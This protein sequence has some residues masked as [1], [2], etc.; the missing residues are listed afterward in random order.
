M[1]PGLVLSWPDENGRRVL[2]HRWAGHVI[3]YVRSV[4][5]GSARRYFADDRDGI[6]VE[7]THRT[8]DAA[9]AAVLAGN[10]ERLGDTLARGTR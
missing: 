6:P 4:D 10:A 8:R 2:R 5:E 9:V 3:G 7:G 1:G